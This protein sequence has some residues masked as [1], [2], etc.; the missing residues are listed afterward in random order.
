MTKTDAKKPWET[1]QPP[2]A[3]LRAFAQKPLTGA[4]L[5]FANNPTEENYNA[6][7]A[8]RDKQRGFN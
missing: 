8:D 3:A 1:P 6:L 4:A 7:V 5:V 2:S